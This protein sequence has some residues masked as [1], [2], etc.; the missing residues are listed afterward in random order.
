MKI[1]ASKVSERP[2]GKPGI[3]FY[4]GVEHGAPHKDDCVM[5]CRKAT[6]RL[7]IEYEVTVPAHWDKAMVDFHRNESSW[8]QGN[9]I[10]ELSKLDENSGCLCGTNAT[11][12]C[13]SL[14]EDIFEGTS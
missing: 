3:C 7:T 6:V 11:F 12:E 4:C 2:A 10:S 8:C 9:L 13:L 1:I 5:V 14:G